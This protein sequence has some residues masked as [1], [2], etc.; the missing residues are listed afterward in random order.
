[1]VFRLDLGQISFNLVKNALASRQL[2]FLATSIAICDIDSGM[3]RNQNFEIVFG[4][5]SVLRLYAFGF[6]E[7]FFPFLFLLFFSFCCSD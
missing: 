2:G 1:M 3:R 5:E 6:L 4:Q 7:F